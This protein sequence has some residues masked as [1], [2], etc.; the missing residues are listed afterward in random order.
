MASMGEVD[1][2]DVLDPQDLEDL[3]SWIDAVPLSRPKKN[4][5]RDFSDGVSV[6]EI[7][8]FYLPRM[9]ELHNYVNANSVGQ[10]RINWSMLN[11]KVFVKI[12]LR[13]NEKLIDNVIE[14]KPGAIEQVLWDL[15]MKVREISPKPILQ[16]S[17]TGNR[18]S[19][20][21]YSENGK[22]APASTGP[23]MMGASSLSSVRQSRLPVKGVASNRSAKVPM[24]TQ[25]RSQ[26]RSPARTN[27]N[28]VGKKLTEGGGSYA[29]GLKDELSQYGTN[30]SLR[31]EPDSSSGANTAFFP[32]VVDVNSNN[33]DSTLPP[34]HLIY[35]GHKMVP[36][37]LLDIKNRQIRDLEL[38]VGSLQKKVNFLDN[39]I[40][41]KDNRVEDL[42]RQ[43]HTLRSKFQELTQTKLPVEFQ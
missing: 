11:R 43:L 17:N 33:G 30:V 32:G 15:R 19:F 2:K 1:E 16:R 40:S 42:T 27:N 12:N 26:L 13:L 10:K 34:A 21:G 6:A 25:M 39:L 23:S 41:L 7:I 18:G 38:V 14:A 37:M 8:H 22:N 29:A 3:Y 31:P 36:S 24:A 9:V 35:K 5:A 4:I 28:E 20:T